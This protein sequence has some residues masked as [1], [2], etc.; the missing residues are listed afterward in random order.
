LGPV[1]E[2]LED[3]P[4]EILVTSYPACEQEI[5]HLLLTEKCPE[6]FSRFSSAQ[7]AV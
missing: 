5:G 4:E 7:D 3:Y 6:A 1:L 2:H